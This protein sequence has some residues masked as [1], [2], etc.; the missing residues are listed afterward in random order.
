LHICVKNETLLVHAFK[1]EHPRIRVTIG[2]DR[3]HCHRARFLESRVD[4]FLMPGSKK[5]DRIVHD[6]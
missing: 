6:Q 5:G 2:V 3:R 4:R 1:Q